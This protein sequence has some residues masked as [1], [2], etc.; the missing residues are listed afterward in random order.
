[1]AGSTNLVSHKLAH[2]VCCPG[3]PTSRALIARPSTAILRQ[4]MSIGVAVRLLLRALAFLV[5]TLFLASLLSTLLFIV[6]ALVFDT[7]GDSSFDIFFEFGDGWPVFLAC[8][9]LAGVI[10]WR[11][12][13]IRRASRV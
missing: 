7:S 9:L 8:L 4:A 2:A 6:V 11:F 12:L 1:M 13:P 10:V 5:L 3:C